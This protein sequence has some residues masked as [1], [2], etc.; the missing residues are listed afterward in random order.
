MAVTKE[1]WKNVGRGF[2]GAFKS[3]GKS[4]VKSVQ[5]G[6]DK[7]GEWAERDDA[8]EAA[9]KEAAACKVCTKNPENAETAEKAE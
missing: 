4:V 5:T 9:K 6:V 3:L 7:A 1:D 8:R 2:A